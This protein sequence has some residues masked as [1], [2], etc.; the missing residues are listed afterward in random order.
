MGLSYD[1]P[2]QNKRGSQM[3]IKKCKLVIYKVTCLT[4]QKI[5]IGLTKRHALVR[6]A[7]H[8]SESRN[9]SDLLFTGLLENME[10]NN[11]LLKRLTKLRIH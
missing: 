7:D 5:Y 11:S 9:G 6:W 1:P 3:T 8:V 2:E 10:S 4:N